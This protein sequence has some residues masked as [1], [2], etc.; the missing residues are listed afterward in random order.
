MASCYGEGPKEA[1][2]KEVVGRETAAS[3]EAAGGLCW[4]DGGAKEIRSGPGN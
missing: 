3:R 1:I 4:V 2:E